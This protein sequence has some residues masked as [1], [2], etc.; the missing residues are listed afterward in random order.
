MPEDPSRVSDLK[1]SENSNKKQRSDAGHTTDSPI[2]HNSQAGSPT[3]TPKTQAELN[4]EVEKLARHP[5]THITRI[6]EEQCVALILKQVESAIDHTY[7]LSDYYTYPNTLRE[8]ERRLAL[9]VGSDSESPWGTEHYGALNSN[10]TT[11]KDNAIVTRG[12]IKTLLKEGFRDVLTQLKAHTVAN[13]TVQSS[14]SSN[15]SIP[16]APKHTGPATSHATGLT[17]KPTRHTTTTSSNPATVT[18]TITKHDPRSA[19]HPSRLVIRCSV[20]PSGNMMEHDLQLVINV[21]L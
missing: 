9:I 13:N 6:L 21:R 8:A 2:S 11:D 5:N 18:T 17:Y 19:H 4:S 3:A 10:T 16:P 12:Q 20:S 7:K 1:W 14:P 15:N